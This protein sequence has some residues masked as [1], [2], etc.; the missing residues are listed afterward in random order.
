MKLTIFLSQS[1]I[2]RAAVVLL[3]RSMALDQRRSDLTE[4]SP[5]RSAGGEWFM[6][7]KTSGPGHGFQ[8]QAYDSA[9]CALT[10][11]ASTPKT[12]CDLAKPGRYSE[13]ARIILMIPTVTCLLVVGPAALISGV[14]RQRA[15]RGQTPFDRNTAV[16]LVAACYILAR[17]IPAAYAGQSSGD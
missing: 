10:N 16:S 8:Y 7:D 9:N 2:G 17:L 4:Q 12:V 11:A 5:D 3:R 6:I 15:D 13:R 1:P 14:R